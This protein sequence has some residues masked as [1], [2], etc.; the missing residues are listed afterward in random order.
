M[1]IDDFLASLQ[2]RFSGKSVARVVIGADEIAEWPPGTFEKLRDANLLSEAEPTQVLECQGCEQSCTMPVEIFPQEAA[3]P[4]RAFIACD[5]RSDVGRVPVPFA[6]L[7]QWQMTRAG[8]GRLQSAW[9][10][11][12][13]GSPRAASFTSKAPVAFRSALERL[14][15]EV[16]QRADR[17]G[18]PFDRRAMPGRKV[19]FQALA[20]KFDGDLERKPRTF[21]DYL[22]G[23]CAFTRGAKA[24]D[25][26]KKLFPE[27]FK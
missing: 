18:L 17:Q 21:D 6:R 23:L 1:G 12:A 10:A 15:V 16:Q 8:F 3:R 11:P 27:F 26:Y 5:K 2:A 22:D 4:A 20:D 19:D 24:S 7:R 14:L 9:V 25:F 13:E